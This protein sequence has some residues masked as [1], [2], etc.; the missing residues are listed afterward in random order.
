MN[1]LSKIPKIFIAKYGNVYVE[2]RIKNK[3]LNRSLGGIG[4][5][6]NA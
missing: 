5:A 1:K 2:K 3:K 6:F 4:E